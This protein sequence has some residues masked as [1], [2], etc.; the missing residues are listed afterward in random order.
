MLSSTHP[1][2]TTRLL[3][4]C[5]YLL[6]LGPGRAAGLVGG[7]AVAAGFVTDFVVDFVVTDFVTDAEP[8][9]VRCTV[10]DR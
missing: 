2:L 1:L 7:F 9:V 3:V 6:G 10:T 5:R 8:G 4:I